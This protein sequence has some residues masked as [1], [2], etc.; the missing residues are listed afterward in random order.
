MSDDGN[1]PVLN[2]FIPS[3]LVMLLGMIISGIVNGAASSFF[4]FR[5]FDVRLSLVEQQLK[6]QQTQLVEA[7]EFRKEINDM[8]KEIAVL[9]TEI[10]DFTK[11]P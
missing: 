6:T 7:Q 4:A 8:A 2:R 1:R 5:D 10:K 11:S 3:A 9:T